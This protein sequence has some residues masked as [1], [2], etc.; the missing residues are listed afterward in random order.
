[1][2]IFPFFPLFTNDL[3]EE[4]CEVRCSNLQRLV[5]N[6]AAIVSG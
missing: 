4:F 5:S 1:V 2:R 6:Q 3:E